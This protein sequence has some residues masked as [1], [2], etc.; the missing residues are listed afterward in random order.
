MIKSEF[1][2]VGRS[3]NEQ[4]INADLVFIGGGRGCG[5]GGGGGFIIFKNVKKGGK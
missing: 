5:G 2:S 4:S 1:S 3:V